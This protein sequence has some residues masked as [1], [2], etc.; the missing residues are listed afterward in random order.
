MKV[1]TL[2]KRL[3]AAIID[4]QTKLQDKLYR[5]ITKKSLAGKRTQAVK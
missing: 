1:K 2:I 5:K 3:Y 4:G